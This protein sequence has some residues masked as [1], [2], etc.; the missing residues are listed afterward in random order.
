MPQPFTSLGPLTLRTFTV[1]LALAILAGTVMAVRALHRQGVRPGAAADISLAGLLG[2]IIGARA[3]HVILH[4]AYF[5]EHT[6]EITRLRAG[7]LDWHGAFAGALV[8]LALMGR[9]R[10]AGMRALLGALALVVPAVGFM[11]WWGCGANLCGYGAEVATMADYPAALVWEAPDVYTLPAP[12]FRTQALGMGAMFALGALLWIMQR[13][14]WLAKYPERHFWLAGMLA[15][16]VMF[17]L[18]FLR[19]DADDLAVWAGL[20]AD[21]WL[22]VLVIILCA[23]LLIWP[24]RALTDGQG[25]RRAA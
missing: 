11:A 25:E 4:W 19:G 22:D 24:R 20:R 3:L 5:Q 10:G 23:L 15:A 14:G 9:L 7:G 17:A 18:S 16:A 1:M 21:Q 2:G 12:R 8:G 13:R 6:V